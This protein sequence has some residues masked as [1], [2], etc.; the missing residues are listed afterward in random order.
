MTAIKLG[1]QQI[2][3]VRN[4]KFLGIYIDYGL[5]WGDHIN[6]ITHKI[7]SGAY[8]LQAVKRYLSLD[9]M[10]F[11]YHGLVHSHQ[12][13]NTD[14][15]M[16]KY[17]RR[18][19]YVIFVMLYIMHR[20]LTNSWVLLNELT[21]IISNSA[22]WSIYTLPPLQT[23]FTSN[24]VVHTYETRHASDPHVAVRKTSIAARTF[25]HQC[26]RAQLALPVD[27][28]KSKTSKPFNKHVKIYYIKQYWDQRPYS[29]A[30][31]CSII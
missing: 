16:S 23:I 14:C 2:L 27:L 18:K 15:I 21:Y 17:C 22:N 6:H 11:L 1:N 10:K 26:P 30:I 12:H 13:L 7:A 29:I 31:T 28:K 4:T 19:P 9:N 5:E 8:A 25:I 24:S 3:Q 20:Q